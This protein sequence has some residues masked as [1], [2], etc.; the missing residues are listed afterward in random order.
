[1]AE[2]ACEDLFC[3]DVVLASW[4]LWPVFQSPVMVGDVFTMTIVIGRRIH[5]LT[6]ISAYELVNS[7]CALEKTYKSAGSR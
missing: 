1:M 4:S 5:Q 2:D 7:S 6:S 3:E